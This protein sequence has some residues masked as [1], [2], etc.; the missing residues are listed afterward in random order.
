[1]VG[2]VVYFPPKDTERTAMGRRLCSS[3]AGAAMAMMSGR[4]AEYFVDAAQG[5]DGN[6]GLSAD[7]PWQSV[8]RV[9]Q[10]ATESTLDF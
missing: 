3:I 1:M 4:A 8:R 10:R 9:N 2:G 7:L 5:R 6:S